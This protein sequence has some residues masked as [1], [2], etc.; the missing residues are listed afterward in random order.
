MILQRMIYPE[1]EIC[2]MEQMYIR[3]IQGNVSLKKGS[4]HLLSDSIAETATYFNAFS[5]GKWK[6]YTDIE[7]VDVHVMIRGKGQLAF[8]YHDTKERILLEKRLYD[9]KE[10][11]EIVFSLSMQKDCHTKAFKKEPSIR[12]GEADAPDTKEAYVY[13]DLAALCYVRILAEEES[14]ITDISYQTAQKPSWQI[15]L[16]IGICT[17]KREEYIARTL[18]MLSE[19]ILSNTES[20]LRDHLNV[21]VSDNGNTL[22]LDQKGSDHINVFYNKNVG[23]AGGFTRCMIEALEDK[24][25]VTHILLMDD[26]IKLHAETLERTWLLLSYLKDT[27][28][29]VVI[30]GALLRAD[31]PVIQHTNAE[32]WDIDRVQ[33]MHRGWDMSDLKNLIANEEN[34]R[35]DYNGWWYCCIPAAKIKEVQLPLPF[36]IHMDDIEYGLRLDSPIIN[37]NGIGVWHDSFDHRKAS[38][39]EY[40]DMRNLLTANVIHNSHYTKEQ[41]KKRVLRHLVF[42]LLKYRYEDWKLTIKGVEDF[43]KGTAF[44]KKTDP[45]LLHQEIMQMGYHFTDQREAL[46]KYDAQHRE[47][48]AALKSASKENELY[49]VKQHSKRDYLTLNGWLLPGKRQTVFLPMGCTSKDLFRV[50]KVVYYDPES[51]KGFA[52]QR[53]WR[54]LFELLWQCHKVSRLLDQKFDQAAADY[55]QNYKEITSMDFWKQYLD[56]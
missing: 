48:T 43:C 10:E 15:E 27:Y 28:K 5:V 2:E 39:M 47:S 42:Q 12:K 56:L 41:A 18:K 34:I 52:S 4:I 33:T 1:K 19:R 24:K 31:R 46:Q 40:Y 51:Q 21:F 54:K 9:S 11:E 32:I 17:Y 53:K 55:R 49:P 29:N 16:A 30:G 23:G 50:K 44:Y 20:P 25:E 13:N 7:H 35:R 22:D 38:S 26:D 8:Y 45:I 37:M 3:T 6:E 14:E 36:F